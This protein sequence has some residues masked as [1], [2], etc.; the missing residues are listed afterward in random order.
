MFVTLFD[1]KSEEWGHKEQLMT[2]EI[3]TIEKARSRAPPTSEK[4]QTQFYS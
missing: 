4:V 3:K 2:C 1:M